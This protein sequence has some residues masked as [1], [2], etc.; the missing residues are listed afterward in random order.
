MLRSDLSVELVDGYRLV[1]C[2]DCPI[3]V[4]VC[5]GKKHWKLY[6]A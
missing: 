2:I 1:M 3:G 6:G 5:I 4:F